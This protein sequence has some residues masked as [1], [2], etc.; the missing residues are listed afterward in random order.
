MDSFAVFRSSMCR[1][2]RTPAPA[3]RLSPRIASLF[4]LFALIV[5]VATAF[6]QTRLDVSQDFLAGGSGGL[7]RISMRQDKLDPT[8][9]WNEGSVRSIVPSENGW[10]FLTSAGL[11][12]SANLRTF[13]NRS[14]GLPAKIVNESENGAFIPKKTSV[15]LKS[16][17]IDPSQPNRLALCTS[18]E[19]WYSDTGGRSW[20][21]LGSPSQVPGMKAVSFGP[22]QGATQLAV[23]VSHSIKG[24]FFRD[25]NAKNGWIGASSGLPKVI[26]ANGEEISSFALIPSSIQIGK[27]TDSSWTLVGGLS[28][29]GKIFQWDPIKKA[30]A[31]RVSDNAEFGTVESLVPAGNNAGFAISNGAIQKILIKTETGALTLAPDIGLTEAAISIK[32]VLFSRYGDTASCLAFYSS[33]NKGDPSARP[34]PVAIGELWLLPTG[35]AKTEMEASAKRRQLANGKSGIYLQTGFVIDPK[36][37][38]KYFALI[39]SQGLNSL[40]VDMKDDYGRLRF[41]PRSP[42]LA[43]AGKTG[44]I[45]DIES[46]AAEAKAQGVY[47]VARIVVF[48]DETLYKWKNGALAVKDASTGAPWRGVKSDGQPIQEFWVDPYSTDV[49]R[50][51]IEIAKEVT[52]RGF[53]EVQFDYIRFPTDGENLNSARFPSQIVGMSQDSALESFLRF[54][55]QELAVPISVDIY[56]ANGWYRSGTRTGQDVEMLANYVD[57]ICPMLYPSHFEQAFM[58]QAP[59]ELRPYRIYKLGTLRNLAIARAKVLVRPYVQAFFLDVSYDRA[60]YGTAYVEQEVRGVREGANQG[61]T[62]WNNSGRYTDLPVLR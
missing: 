59:T 28:F 47:L 27:A 53:D 14:T 23:W 48:K 2:N 43:A 55:R 3:R 50:Y 6:A 21:S 57:V 42:L 33:L 8:L 5:P 41:A 58:A 56:G 62:F 1:L 61:M 15:E 16:L 45:L 25:L 17:A 10:Y 54:A 19:V 49:W 60:F 44:E 51:N 26:G 31:E 11:V 20:I 34:L 39:K 52:S 30:F 12:F 24:A 13:E 29:L 36:T 38:A 7:Y 22:L 18:E 46:F 4:L 40:V 32:D 35:S 37:R 9:I